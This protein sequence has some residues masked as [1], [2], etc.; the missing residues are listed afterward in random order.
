MLKFLKAIVVGLLLRGVM[1]GI[2]FFI[3]LGLKIFEMYNRDKY[4]RTHRHN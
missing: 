3:A 4:S 2:G 1:L